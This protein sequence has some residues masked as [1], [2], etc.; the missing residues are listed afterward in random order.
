MTPCTYLF[1][2][3]METL[4]R[5]KGMTRFKHLIVNDLVPVDRFHA[6]VFD[7]F[8]DALISADTEQILAVDTAEGRNFIADLVAGWGLGGCHSAG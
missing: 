1:L 7:N 4:V 3:L 2:F 6:I 8:G 5:Y